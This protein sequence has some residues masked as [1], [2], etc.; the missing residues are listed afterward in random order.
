MLR[1]YLKSLEIILLLKKF[2][3]QTLHN[4]EELVQIHK[5]LHDSLDKLL[6]CFIESTGKNLTNTNL[7][8]FMNWSF[9]QTKNPTCYKKEDN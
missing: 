7:M 9:N 6:A 8:E 5:E 1:N 3:V 4:Q 2:N